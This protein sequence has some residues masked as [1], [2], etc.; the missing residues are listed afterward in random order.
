MIFWNFSLYRLQYYFNN[1]S[2]IQKWSYRT[3]GFLLEERP[4]VRRHTKVYHKKKVRKGISYQAG[5]LETIYGSSV[6]D[7]KSSILYA[8]DLKKL[9]RYFDYSLAI[10]CL[11]RPSISLDSLNKFFIR[12]PY[13]LLKSER[14]LKDHSIDILS[15]ERCHQALQYVEDLSQIVNHT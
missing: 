13:N 2:F 9:L 15:V 3:T 4:L 10:I 6:R 8:E 1:E 5:L 14:F 7:L 12:P 11:W